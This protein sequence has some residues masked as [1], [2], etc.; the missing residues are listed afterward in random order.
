MALAIWI[1]LAAWLVVD[2]WI[3]IKA[4]P[5]WVTAAELAKNEA[6]GVRPHWRT[7]AAPGIWWAAAITGVLA[8]GLLATARWWAVALDSRANHR[9]SGGTGVLSP[10]PKV[11]GLGA[12][13]F[14]IGLML[15]VLVGS[16]A[17]LPLASKS[18]WWDELWALKQASHGQWREDRR[19][20]GE[21]RFVETTWDRAAWYFLKPTNHPVATLAQKASLDS[22]RALSGAERHEFSDLAV[23]VPSLIA[24]A[25]AVFGVGLLLRT[26]GMPVAGLLAAALLALHPWAIRYGVD[27]RAYAMLLPLVPLALLWITQLHRQPWRWRWWWLLSATQFLLLW[28]FPNAVPLAVA[29]FLTAAVVLWHRLR[30]TGG[31]VR[32]WARLVAVHVVASMAFFHAFLPNLMQV[33]QWGPDSQ[34]L[35]SGPVLRDTLTGLAVGMP[36][37]ASDAGS[38]VVGWLTLREGFWWPSVW[39]GFHGLALALG[40]LALWHR[41]R[42]GL[43]AMTLSFGLAA[44]YVAL[45][46]WREIYF[47][48][49]YLIYL[50]P[51]LV[52]LVAIGWTQSAAWFARRVRA[53]ATP[54]AAVTGAVALGWFVALVWP[55]L[56]ILWQRPISPMHDTIRFIQAQPGGGQAVIIAYGLGG[57]VLDVYAPGVVLA[58]NR[59]TI[60]KGLAIAAEQER[61][62]W[63]VR[64]YDSFDRQQVPEGFELIDDPQWFEFV[65][66]FDGIE[67]SFQYRVYR[68]IER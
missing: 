57:R 67:V 6:D 24:S 42:V 37:R 1:I 12:K 5:P 28:S 30:P 10:W 27:S 55:Q 22:W 60:K 45:S 47:Y 7:Q 39:L 62:A 32:A 13:W 44:V 35:L 2:V 9:A 59:E 18:L 15:L 29:L 43:L 63:L 64:G 21:L 54:V 58:H 19:N 31:Q 65:T 11:R 41:S 25:V 66:D 26:W 68:A 36:Y 4:E 34:L 52:M 20:P 14:W 16:A 33:F 3:V 51:L 8:L 46:W 38:P 50:L 17:R 56:Q 61:P 23:R 53:S 48:P 40:L 49:R